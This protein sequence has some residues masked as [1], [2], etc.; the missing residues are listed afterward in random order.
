MPM[1]GQ[2]VVGPPG[3][4]KT[5]YCGAMTQY[6]NALGRNAVVVNLDP[7]NELFPRH[8]DNNTSKNNNNNNN[9]NNDNKSQDNNNDDPN[10]NKNLPY[11]PIFDVT[12]D[13]VRLSSVMERYDLGPNGALLYCMEYLDEHSDTFLNLLEER[14]HLHNNN[15]NNSSNNNNNNMSNGSQNSISLSSSSSS[16]PLPPPYVMFDLPGQAELYAHCN[17]IRSILYKISKRFDLRLACINIVDATSCIDPSRFICSGCVTSLCA[18]VRL[19]LPAVNVLGKIDLLQQQDGRKDSGG[20]SSEDD[21]RGSDEDHDDTGSNQRT[22]RKRLKNGTKLPFDL[23][24]FTEC[25]DLERLVNHIESTE[26]GYD[27]DDEDGYDENDYYD[28]DDNNNNNNSDDEYGTTPHQRMKQKNQKQ[29]ELLL[30][31]QKHHEQNQRKQRIK[32][33]INSDESYQKA[34]YELSNSHYRKMRRKFH[35]SLCEIADDYGLLSYVILDLHDGD[36][37][38]VGRLLGRIDRCNGYVFVGSGSGEE[39]M[40]SGNGE[41]YG[42]GDISNYDDM[43]G[44]IGS[45]S[46]EDLFKC[47]IAEDGLDRGDY[48]GLMNVRERYLGT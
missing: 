35:Q 39:K 12:E 30:K 7:A 23:S 18:T 28:D 9:S 15:V 32:D 48:E 5:T 1:Y 40:N 27:D 14:L 22:Q 4:G 33:N 3:S 47:A 17:V 31:K 36:G 25:R 20:S 10:K 34:S 26:E 13:V 41:G 42:Y 44:G 8:T 19:E 46:G 16:K 2:A 45:G 6:L 37:G 24:F 29:K 11:V 38:S 43:S 21:N